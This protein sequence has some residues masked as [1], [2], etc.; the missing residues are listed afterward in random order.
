MLPVWVVISLIDRQ[1]LIFQAFTRIV[2]IFFLRKMLPTKN[3]FVP[4]A[5][6]CV[7]VSQI[8][9]D[10]SVFLRSADTSFTRINN[11]LHENTQTLRYYRDSDVENLRSTVVVF[12]TP[13]PQT[14]PVVRTTIY[15]SAP[16]SN[17]TLVHQMTALLLFK[18]YVVFFVRYGQNKLSRQLLCTERN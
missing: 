9:T 12:S 17:V 14:S 1:I 3:R 5:C 8:H 16:L 10:S 18:L 15:T 2:L 13:G 4:H 7:R 11:S 6:L